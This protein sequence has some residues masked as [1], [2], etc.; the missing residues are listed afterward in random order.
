MTK[1]QVIC[2]YCARP[3]L[4]VGGE[5][6]Y[7]NRADLFEKH[8]WHC[9]PCGAYV[10]CHGNNGHPGNG[11]GT[12]ALG[13]LANAE[14]RQ[15]KIAAHAAFDPLWRNGGMQRKKAYAWLSSAMRLPPKDTHIGFFD[16]AQCN[17]VVTVVNQRR[18]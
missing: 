13:R 6:I 2:P 4:L 9:A 14:L 10:G 8:F 17:E 1:S 15:A 7:P 18:S 12:V 3:A 11:D 5:A 16:V